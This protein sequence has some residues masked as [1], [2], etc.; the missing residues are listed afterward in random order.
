MI[1]TITYEGKNT[2]DLGYLL[3]K[4]P[5]RPQVFNMNFGKAYVFYPEVSEERTTAALLLSI[6]PVDL[7][8]GKEGSQ[9][10]GLFD[11]VNDRPYVAS[12]FMSTAISS[13]F[14]TAMTGRADDHQELSDS[15]LDL[16]ATITMLPCRGKQEMLERVFA[17][18]GYQVSYRSFML[19]DE[20]PQWGE[21]P[22]VELKLSQKIRLRD[23]L[24]HLYLLI[25]VF[26]RQKHYWVGSAEVD[27]LLSHGEE[28]LAQHPEKEFIVRR[29]FERKR[30]FSERVLERLAGD[31]DMAA[32]DAEEILVDPVVAE[33]KQSLNSL[34]L[35]AAFQALKETGARSVIDMGCG[36]GK[37]LKLLIQEPQFVKIAGFDVAV[38]EL[39]K[40]GR[41]LKLDQMNDGA[42]ERIEIFQSSIVYKDKRFSEYEAAAVVEVIEHLDLNRL[43]A[44]ER[45]LFG[46]TQP[47]FVVLTTPNREYNEKYESLTEE[48]RHGDHR[49]EWSRAEFGAWGRRI[50]EVY[51]YEVA[52][53]EIGEADEKL[54]A[55][56]QMGVFTRCK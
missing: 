44:F 32:P 33:K 17:P 11:Y 50:A 29:Y 8:R 46:I 15:L 20:A 13:V 25:P 42:R 10:Q 12:S 16:T 56:T 52:F 30:S 31:G 49:F 22:Y 18:L 3:Y 28:W 51:G 34:R 35:E 41:R 26:D 53:S 39:E 14:G 45:I 54:G 23:L 7:A 6:D 40:A 47:K 1:L 55:P 2:Q 5:N 36:E 21:S 43:D 4:N 37:L 9:S 38:S 24:K 19:D 27:K 48:M